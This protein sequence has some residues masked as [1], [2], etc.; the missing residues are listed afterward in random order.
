[1]LLF[2]PICDA[3]KRFTK[4]S[5]ENNFQFP[6]IS[7]IWIQGVK[8]RIYGNSLEPKINAKYMKSNSKSSLN[9]NFS[10]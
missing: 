3:A 6:I 5:P 7:E 1:M 10:E 9:E 8:I 2:F 4:Q